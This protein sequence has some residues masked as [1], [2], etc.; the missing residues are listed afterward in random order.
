MAIR[1]VW[2]EEGCIS[3]GLCEDTASEIFEVPGGSTSRTKKGHKKLLVGDLE[4]DELIREA[5]QGCPVEVIHYEE[6]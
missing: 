6:D 1:K 5:E 3:C 4:R 2:I